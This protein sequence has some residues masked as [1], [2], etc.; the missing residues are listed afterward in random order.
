[1]AEFADVEIRLCKDPNKSDFSAAAAIAVEDERDHRWKTPE[2]W[3]NREKR[4]TS[5]IEKES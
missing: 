4:I 1:V 5:T 3:P 2:G